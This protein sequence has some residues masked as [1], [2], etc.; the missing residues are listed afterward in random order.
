MANSEMANSEMANSGDRE[1]ETEKETDKET[2]EETEE[3]KT[4]RLLEERC[5]GYLVGLHCTL[6]GQ[7][8]E[9]ISPKGRAEAVA[10]LADT[11]EGLTS[12]A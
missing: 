10:W 7:P 11:I 2:E 12:R 1:K 5:D 6:W 9:I 3:E 4:R 8:F